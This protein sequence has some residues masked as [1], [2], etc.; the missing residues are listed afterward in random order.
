MK[1]RIQN[2]GSRYAMVQAARDVILRAEHHNDAGKQMREKMYSTKN[3]QGKPNAFGNGP[4]ASS[5]SAQRRS[6]KISGSRKDI[7]MHPGTY[8]YQR[9][10]AYGS[11]QGQQLTNAMKSFHMQNRLK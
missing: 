5:S 1:K 7:P 6:V 11:G 8:K 2:S 4:R 9:H 3:R 10:Q